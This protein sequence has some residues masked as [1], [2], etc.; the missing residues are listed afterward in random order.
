MPKR[1]RVGQSYGRRAEEGEMVARVQTVTRSEQV[2][3]SAPA[4]RRRTSRAR[5]AM[6]KPS[7]LRRIG[8]I[9]W[10]LPLHTVLALT[11][12]VACGALAARFGGIVAPPY[13]AT[14]G[15]VVV[16]P[17]LVAV[18]RRMPRRGQPSC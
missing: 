3:A 11:T 18:W 12:G 5:R 2:T 9:V 17:A 10:V 14:F 1:C 13:A 15:A 7:A 4:R 8:R 6:T 16:Y